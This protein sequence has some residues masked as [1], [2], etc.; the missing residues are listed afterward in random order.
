MNGQLLPSNKKLLKAPRHSRHSSSS[1]RGEPSFYKEPPAALRKP[2]SLSAASK[3]IKT[4][5]GKGSNLP[6]PETEGVSQT[7]QRRTKIEAGGSEWKGE[8]QK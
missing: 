2:V 7:E 3:L 4:K 1:V 6:L 5:R 8:I